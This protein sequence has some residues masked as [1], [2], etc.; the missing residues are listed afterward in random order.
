MWFFKSAF[1]FLRWN[2][3]YCCTGDCSL[4][5]DCSIFSDTSSSESHNYRVE[6]SFPWW[7]A[8]LWSFLQSKIQV[9]TDNRNVGQKSWFWPKIEILVENRNFRRTSKFLLKNRNFRRKPI[10][11]TRN[12]LIFV[13]NPVFSKSSAKYHWYGS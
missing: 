8:F 4:L 2:R 10:F 12:F 11:H 9:L 13:K 5:R 1:S 3:L 7:S 6:N